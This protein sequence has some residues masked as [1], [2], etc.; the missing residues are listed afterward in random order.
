MPRLPQHMG[1]VELIREVERLRGVLTEAANICSD[2]RQYPDA[3]V[4][5]DRVQE[6]VDRALRVS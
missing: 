4:A 1:R 5:L 2:D 3:D 6:A